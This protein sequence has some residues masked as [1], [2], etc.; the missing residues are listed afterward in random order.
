MLSASDDQIVTESRQLEADDWKRQASPVRGC[1]VVDGS[2]FSGKLRR[3]QTSWI[4]DVTYVNPL[5]HVPTSDSHSEGVDYSRTR[6]AREVG[7]PYVRIFS[8]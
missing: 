7:G 2:R 1:E 4:I 3:L 5:L 8:V 6:T